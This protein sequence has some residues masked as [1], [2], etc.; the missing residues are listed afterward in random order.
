MLLSN[1]KK[2]NSYWLISIILFLWN[3]VGYKVSSQS[4]INILFNVLLFSIL[5][6][7]IIYVYLIFIDYTIKIIVIFLL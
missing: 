4:N 1:S 3:D 5:L 7:I 2:Y 6:F